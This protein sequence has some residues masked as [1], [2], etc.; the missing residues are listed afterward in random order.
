MKVKVETRRGFT[1]IELL[2]VIAIIAVLIAL[3][4][5]A[6]QS[7]REAA[8]RGQCS[9]N[10]KQIGLG[11]HNYHSSFGSFPIG[12]SYT[13]GYGP[14]PG[15]YDA[16]WGTWNAQGLML[17]YLE[18]GGLYNSSNFSWS[19]GFGP[20][21][22][23]NSTVSQA[24]LS[25]FV[26]PSDGLSPIRASGQ[27]G[28]ISQKSCFQWTG[29]TN[30]YFASL[31]TSTAY[32]QGAGGVTPTTG[33]FT[34]GGTANGVQAVSDGTNNTIA[35]GEG[36]IGDGT[37]QLVKWRDGPNLATASAVCSGGWCGVYDISAS[38]WPMSLPTSTPA[39]RDSTTSRSPSPQNT[40]PI[41]RDSGGFS[42]TAASACSTQSPRRIHP[43]TRLGGVP[44]RGA[45]RIRNASDGQY[46]TRPAATPAGATTC[47][48]TDTSSS[49]SR[50]SPSGRTGRSAPRP[51][52]RSSRQTR[53]DR[54]A[55]ARDFWYCAFGILPQRGATNRPRALPCP[56]TSRRV[57]PLQ[58]LKGRHIAAAMFRPY[59]A[60]APKMQPRVFVCLRLRGVGIVGMVQR[61]V[62]APIPLNQP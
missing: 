49:S 53:I 43:S 35:F 13:P 25:V 8:R 57:N 56:G 52:A 54:S 2:V 45:R 30:N 39:R 24:I 14:P 21:F 3:L 20:G 7:A 37:I 32:G 16:S 46:Q 36:L 61:Q 33:V 41:R 60:R 12:A 34:Q 29:S 5:P 10:L 58:A 42:P 62:T 4:L 44:S 6:V 47:S 31:G 48:A 22:L 50:R 23:I 38:L 1:L 15:G 17:G 40:S 11:M 9:N 19:V 59:R 55:A 28:N 26:C 18:Q 27:W 51:T